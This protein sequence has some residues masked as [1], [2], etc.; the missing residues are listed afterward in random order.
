M[1]PVKVGQIFSLVRHMCLESNF[2][3]GYLLLALSTSVF[4]VPELKINSHLVKVQLTSN[5]VYRM[6][7]V[8]ALYQENWFFL[9]KYK[10]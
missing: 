4:F 8:L 3:F 5:T 10:N 1:G 6:I 7:Y 2:F 9:L